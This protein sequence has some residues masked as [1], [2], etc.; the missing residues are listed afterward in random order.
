MRRV[1]WISLL[2]LG[3]GCGFVDSQLKRGPNGEPSA[4]EN[5][6]RAI[7]PLGGPWGQVALGA[8]TL[9]ASVW[10]GLHAKQANQNTKEEKVG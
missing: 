8:V 2:L 5:E 6:V 7:A 1:L 3:A 4:L 10:A 9:A